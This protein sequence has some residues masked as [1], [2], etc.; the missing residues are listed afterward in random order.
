VHIRP[1]TEADVP[2]ITVIYNEAVRS[3]TATFD[4]DD[5]SIDNRR[6]WFAAHGARH[7]VIVCE[8][9]GRVVG[10]ACLSA[11][12][13]RRAYDGTCE[14]SVYV[15]ESARG[16]GAGRSLLAELVRLAKQHEFHTIIARI[17]DGNP[18][19]ERLHD[20]AGFTKVGTMREVGRKFGRLI[21]VHAYQLMLWR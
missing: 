11:W 10:W 13:D 14:N 17:A 19:S 15:A 6:A 12:S 16:N 9:A 8:Q 7:P 4:T 1:A 3:S 2:A 21:D 5:K 20:A 18:V